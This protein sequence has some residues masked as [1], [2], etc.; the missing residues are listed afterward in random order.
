[1]RSPEERGAGLVSTFAGL[2]VVLVLLLFA[3]ESLVGL[4][5]STT[6]TGATHA[7]AR[8][9][10]SDVRLRTGADPDQALRDADAELRSALGGVGEHAEVSW[11]WDDDQ[12]EVHARMPRPG[13]LPPAWRGAGAGRWIDRTV[14]VRVE[15]L[16]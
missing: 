3:V 16:R 7:A 12:L 14:H 15:S 9:A 13:V 6:L 5:A 1:V 2:L 8:H 10:A 11:S 4:Y